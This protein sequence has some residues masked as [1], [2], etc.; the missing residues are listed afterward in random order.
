MPP[1]WLTVGVLPQVA[2][3]GHHDDSGV[4]GVLG[5]QRQRIGAQD[6]VTAAP[7]ERLTTRTLY[8]ALF[9]TTQPSAA[10][11]ADHAATVVIQHLQADEM[12]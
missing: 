6:S 1:C 8:E 7:T 5:S 9:A 12:R 3:G 10:M 2:R 11:T 4:D